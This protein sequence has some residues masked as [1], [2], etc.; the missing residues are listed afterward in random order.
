MENNLKPYGLLE[1]QQTC[2]IHKD[3]EISATFWAARCHH[4]VPFN[5]YLSSLVLLRGEGMKR[6][7]FQVFCF[8]FFK[9]WEHQDIHIH[10]LIWVFYTVA[11]G[12]FCHFKRF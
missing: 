11:I 2:N 4:V 9:G 12:M 10:S 8:S 6:C 1:P 7:V 3:P 5:P